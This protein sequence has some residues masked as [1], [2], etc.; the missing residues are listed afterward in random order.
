MLKTGYEMRFF[1]PLT[2][3]PEGWGLQA[4]ATLVSP[5]AWVSQCEPRQLY[6]RPLLKHGNV[7]HTS[8]TTHRG[9]QFC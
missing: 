1:E 4:V 7:S 8:L 5:R 2:C 3:A 9:D 6:G